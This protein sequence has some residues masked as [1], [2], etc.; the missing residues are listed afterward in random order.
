MSLVVTDVGEKEIL[1]W[2]FKDTGEGLKLNLFKNDYTPTSTSINT[3]FTVGDF[4]GYVEKTIARTDF[5]SATTNANNKGEIVASD[6]SW[7]PTSAQD[8]YGYYV[9]PASDNTVV[10]WAEKF[11]SVVSL[12]SGDTFTVKPKMTLASEA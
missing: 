6:Q 11:A 12:A 4:T 8:I 10:L 1:D 7:S 2:A 5:T 9:S 3:D